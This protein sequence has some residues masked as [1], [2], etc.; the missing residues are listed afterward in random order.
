MFITMS[1]KCFQVG[2][3][4]LLLHLIV[5][6]VYMETLIVSGQCDK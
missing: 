3:S 1:Y 6:Y 4:T 5:D 2:F